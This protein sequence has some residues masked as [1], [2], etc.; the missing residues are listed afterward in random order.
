VVERINLSVDE[1]VGDLLSDLAGGERKRGQWLS[2][3]VRA[4]HEA[5]QRVHVSDIEQVKLAF[6]GLLGQ[7]KQ[8]EGRVI[9]LER[10]V[11]AL[12]ASG[13]D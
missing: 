10:Q 3:L 6:S 8:L 2:D 12:M 9:Q 4:M 11:S 1:G 7:Q 13:T 5:G